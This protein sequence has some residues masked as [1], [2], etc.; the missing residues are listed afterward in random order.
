MRTHRHLSWAAAVRAHR[1]GRP[2]LTG[3]TQIPQGQG[4]QQERAGRVRPQHDPQP[5]GQHLAGEHRRPGRFHAPQREL[6]VAE[7]DQGVRRARGESLTRIRARQPGQARSQAQPRL[8]GDDEHLAQAAHRVGPGQ[9]HHAAPGSA[10]LI[11]RAGEPGDQPAQ[12][13]RP[14]QPDRHGG[15]L[16]QG[17]QALRRVGVWAGRSGCTAPCRAQRQAL[18][19]AFGSLSSPWQRGQIGAFIMSNDV[20]LQ[21]RPRQAPGH[22]ES[23]GLPPAA[24]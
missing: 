12:R 2:V 19:Q 8:L 13:D 1:T 18:C 5:V 15:Q 21:P 24:G 16:E 22:P 7:L 20:D 14:G 23:R 9:G 4:L 17:V 11:T 3:I 6:V 10:A